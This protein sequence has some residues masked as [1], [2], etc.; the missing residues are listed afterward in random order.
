[1]YKMLRYEDK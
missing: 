1:M